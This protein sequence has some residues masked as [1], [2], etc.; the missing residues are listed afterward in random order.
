[1]ATD[2]RIAIATH[3]IVLSELAKQ[4]APDKRETGH[5]TKEKVQSDVI[6]PESVRS[7]VKRSAGHGS[8]PLIEVLSSCDSGDSEVTSAVKCVTRNDTTEG[9]DKINGMSPSFIGDKVSGGG[10]TMS[11]SN[12]MSSSDTMST[13]VTSTSVTTS[14]CDTKS[15]DVTSH[16]DVSPLDGALQEL[17]DS[18]VPVRGHALITLTHLLQERDP[19]TLTRSVMLLKVFRENL[20]HPDTYIY[21]QAVAGLAALGDCAPDTVLPTLLQEYSQASHSV[22]LRVK[23]GEAIVKICRRLGE[24]R[25]SFF[26]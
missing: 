11:S 21:L 23:L 7:E 8:A 4:R 3:G 14:T 24:S 22:E 18:L 17:C 6:G 20:D 19:A 12:T 25:F 10:D 26:V 15:A 16:S 1:M 9:R 5:G 13:G 2:L